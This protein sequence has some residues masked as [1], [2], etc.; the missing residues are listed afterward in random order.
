MDT[1]DLFAKP[2]RDKNGRFIKGNT[3]SVGNAGGNKCEYCENPQEILKK[4]ILYKEWCRGKVDGKIHHPYIQEMISED[5]LDITYDQF[6]DWVKSIDHKV[7]HSELT[8]TVSKIMNRQQLN[9][10]KMTLRPETYRGAKF[11]LSANHGMVEAEKRI[12]SGDQDNPQRH[13]LEIEI[14]EAKKNQ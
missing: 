8:R 7:E 1:I 2:Q 9:L 11:Q 12:V 4:V 3:L 10:L 14:T 5:Y 13:K 6:E